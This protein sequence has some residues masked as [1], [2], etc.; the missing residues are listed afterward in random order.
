MDDEVIAG[1]LAAA[2]MSAVEFPENADW[3]NS[4]PLSI[5]GAFFRLLII[6]IDCNMIN[7]SRFLPEF[8][9]VVLKLV[10]NLNIYWVL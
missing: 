10:S 1:H 9:W 8:C 7:G 3:V 5:H 6:G 2:S 4:S